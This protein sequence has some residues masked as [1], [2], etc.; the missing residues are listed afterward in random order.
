MTPAFIMPD[1]AYPHSGNLSRRGRNSPSIQCYTNPYNDC[2]PKIKRESP[3]LDECNM[4][5][6]DLDPSIKDLSDQEDD[7]ND[8]EEV[9]DDPMILK[10]QLEAA[11]IELRIARIKAK[12]GQRK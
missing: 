1:F 5:A 12:M 6:Q 4:S 2:R 10:A 8:D 7:N 9:E 11:E 3:S